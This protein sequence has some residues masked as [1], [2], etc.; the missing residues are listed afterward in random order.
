MQTINARYQLEQKI[1]EGGMGEVHLATDRLTSQ[2]IA[3]KQVRIPL[4]ELSWLSK[5][6]AHQTINDLRLGLA[7]EFQI[8]ATLRHPHII[9][10]LDYRFDSD[11]MPF[12]TMEFLANA[13]TILE[14]AAPLK[15]EG[16]L[17][18]VRQMLQ[19]LTYLHRRQ[20]MHRDLKPNNILVSNN[21]VKLVDFG[22]S[23]HKGQNGTSSGTLLYMA[24][25]MLRN[26]GETFVE[27][28]DLY[29]VGIILY[30]LF[31]GKHPYDTDSPKFA[32]QVLHDPPDISELNAEEPLAA[33]VARLLA[34]TPAERY[35]DAQTCLVAFE[36]ALGKVS[37]SE[38]HAIRESY[39]QA[40]SFIGRE[41]EL[42]WLSSFLKK[43]KEEGSRCCL[44]GGE[45]GVGK[46][47]LIGRVPRPRHCRRV[48]GLV[49]SN[50]GGGNPLS[51]LARY[52]ASSHPRH[53]IE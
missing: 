41:K 15:L 25:E 42:S 6:S 37:P 19:A 46:S 44:L 35:P 33:F 31:A 1:G 2:K 9:S 30:Q 34:K 5:S 52:F 40:A 7:R 45:S 21:Q 18:L 22:L 27:A 3:L 10:V 29:S 23:S 50:I 39:L 13:K 24:P 47:P 12:Y 16:K 8:L 49:S 14:A 36:E 26:L 43:T 38:T 20:V 28:T 53:R 11:S 48:G 51:R 4:A 32:N 17:D